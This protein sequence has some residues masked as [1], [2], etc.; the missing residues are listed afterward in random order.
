MCN[1]TVDLSVR[2]I[3][4]AGYRKLWNLIEGGRYEW[5]TIDSKKVDVP[6]TA[7]K[8]LRMRLVNGSLDKDPSMTSQYVGTLNFVVIGELVT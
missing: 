3:T 6:T 7:Y 4:Q 5:T 2:A 1:P 8:Q